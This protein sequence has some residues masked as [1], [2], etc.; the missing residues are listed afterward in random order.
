[1]SKKVKVCLAMGGGVSLGTFSGASL[2]VAIKLLLLFGLDKK[3]N[4]YTDVVI[5]G[6]SGA[7]AGAIALVIMLKSLIDYKKMMTIY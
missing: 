3:G 1:M 5:D 7:S 6:M 2:T 4:K